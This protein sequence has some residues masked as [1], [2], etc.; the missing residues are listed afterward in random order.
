MSAAAAA[1]APKSPLEL[2]GQFHYRRYRPH[3]WDSRSPNLWAKLAPGDLEFQ[4]HCRAQFGP[5]GFPSSGEV[6]GVAVV[7]CI[8]EQ[9][10]QSKIAAAVAET[11][12]VAANDDAGSWMTTDAEAAREI[13]SIRQ[14]SSGAEHC[15]CSDLNCCC[16]C[17]RCL[18]GT[19]SRAPISGTEAPANELWN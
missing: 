1:A 10:L 13:R 6:A 7:F 18:A 16:R 9:G 8:A 17:Q 15:C 14:G 19:D 11:F 4:L 12:V 5:E 3:K 2:G